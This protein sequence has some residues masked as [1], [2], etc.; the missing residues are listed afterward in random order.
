[1]DLLLSRSRGV[2]FGPA[3]ERDLADRSRA[4]A[5]AL[6]RVIARTRT[7]APERWLLAHGLRTL[8]SRLFVPSRFPR[9]RAALEASARAP[10]LDLIA[11]DYSAPMLANQ[12][13][14]V[15]GGY[16]PW[17]WE[18]DAEGL[19]DVLRASQSDG[20]PLLVAENGMAVRRALDGEAQVRRDGVTRDD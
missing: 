10:P 7:N 19:F 17:D 1:V 12:L 2:A 15:A 6:E 13:R 16:D 14:L 18:V 11:L 3:L 8:A 5:S 20:L 4:N 9:L